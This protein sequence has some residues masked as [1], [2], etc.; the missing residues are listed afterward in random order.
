MP[1]SDLW[2]LPDPIIERTQALS[3]LLAK[4]VKV[5]GFPSAGS[6]SPSQ[7]SFFT[8]CLPKIQQHVGSA[9]YRSTWTQIIGGLPSSSVLQSIF[10]S[11]FSSI[12]PFPP[13]DSSPPTRNLVKSE[14]SLL[15]AI[16]GDFSPENRDLWD[17][18]LGISQNRDFDEGRARILAC[19][20]AFTGNGSTD[21]AGESW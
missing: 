17:V 3:Y 6:L 5:G 13:L 1:S 9:L 15:R 19:W 8:V 12:R 16:L 20:A 18:V 11:L 4:L 2:P 14:A 7:P 10:V 21:L